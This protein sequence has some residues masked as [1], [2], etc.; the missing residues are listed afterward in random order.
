MAGT[1]GPGPAALGYGFWG[2]RLKRIVFT[3]PWRRYRARELVTV[4]ALREE[5]GK[6]APVKLAAA[7]AGGL[8]LGGAG[9][10]VGALA[11]GNRDRALLKLE[12][13]DG[14]WAV[15]QAKGPDAMALIAAAQRRPE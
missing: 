3:S 11:L 6:L 4:T 12:F 5:H 10:I 15:V 1:F 2:R 7:A 8:L 13:S 9:A 14:G